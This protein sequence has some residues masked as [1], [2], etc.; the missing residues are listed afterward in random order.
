MNGHAASQARKSDGRVA[1]DVAS[2]RRWTGAANKQDLRWSTEIS[3]PE[4]PWPLRFYFVRGQEDDGSERWVLAGFEAGSPVPRHDERDTDE[5]ELDP[6]RV[7]LLWQN[8]ARYAGMAEALLI[9]T[10]ENRKTAARKRETMGRRRGGRLTDDYLAV[11]L[12]EYL[13]RADEDDLT[14]A[15]AAERG[16][17]RQTVW[18]HLKEAR[19]RGL[20]PA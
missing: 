9:P 20:N 2:R 12:S 8:F 15:M 10:P 14:F 6:R 4:L 16:I 13:A 3:V 11:L 7:A 18:R 17:T 5:Y 1:F 19:R